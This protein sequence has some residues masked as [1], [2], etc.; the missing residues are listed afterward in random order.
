VVSMIKEVTGL[1]K[2]KKLLELF[3]A[4]VCIGP[5]TFGGGYAMIPVIEREV[6]GKRGW[7]DSTEMND[8]LSIAGSAPG[9]VGVN[10]AALI[11]YRIGGVLGASAAVAGITLPT[12]GIVFALYFAYGWFDEYPKAIAALKGIHSAIIALILVAAYKVAKTSLVDKTTIGV[13]VVTLTILFFTEINPA[14]IIIAGLL[15][16]I[17]LV[18]VKEWLGMRVSME[19]RFHRKIELTYP[20]YYI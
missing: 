9:G 20:E 11:G 15:I 18:K 1:G 3:W 16:G 4:F 7:F 17:I 8:L 13:A 12:F 14:F 2:K 5:A 10:A 6:V 19:K